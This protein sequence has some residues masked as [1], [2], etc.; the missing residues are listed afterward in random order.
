M[1]D[2]ET[3]RESGDLAANEPKAFAL[4]IATLVAEFVP[5]CLLYFWYI[6]DLDLWVAALGVLGVCVFACL[7]R[8][9]SRRTRR[10][11]TA[12]GSAFLLAV[13]AACLLLGSERSRIVGWAPL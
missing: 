5:G 9:H 8:L 13:L 7:L 10:L 2:S 4:C 6:E 11:L 12:S 1:T 3:E